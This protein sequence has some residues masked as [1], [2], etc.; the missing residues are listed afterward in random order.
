MPDRVD[1]ILQQWARERPDLDVSPIAVIGRISRLSRRFEQEI[2]R[3]LGE[4][5]LTPD[6][7]DVLATLRRSGKPYALNP[8]A[9]LGSMMVSSATVTHRLDKLEARGLVERLPDPSDRRGVVARLTPSGRRLVDR[10]SQRHYEDE[11]RLL[12][13]LSRQ[14]RATL[15]DLLRRLAEANDC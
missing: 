14:D 8:R 5:G 15:A 2:G 12:A 11:D 13:T 6:E 9:L 7:Y 1:F 4:F 10:A 3:H